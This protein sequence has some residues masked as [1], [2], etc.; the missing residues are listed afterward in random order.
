MCECEDPRRITLMLDVG[1]L[2]EVPPCN[3]SILLLSRHF[4]PA[5]S[6]GWRKNFPTKLIC[7][8]IPRGNY[9]CLHDLYFLPCTEHPH[10]VPL[11]FH[12][13]NVFVSE[14]WCRSLPRNSLSEEY[15]IC[16]TEHN[17]LDALCP[18]LCGKVTNNYSLKG[19]LY[20]IKCNII[21][22]SPGP[23]LLIWVGLQLLIYI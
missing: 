22:T 4:L 6:S 13:T 9:Y 12:F 19:D 23:L 11:S 8:I 18:E 14:F 7:Y 2:Q 3:V 5:S 16:D 10:K 15:F 20:S 17:A 21:E 1:K